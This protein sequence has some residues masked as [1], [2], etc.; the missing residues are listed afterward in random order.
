MKQSALIA[1]HEQMPPWNAGCVAT[2]QY[3]LLGCLLGCQP[4]CWNAV[5]ACGLLFEVPGTSP[6]HRVGALRSAATCLP[7]PRGCSPGAGT[8]WCSSKSFV[9]VAV[10]PLCNSNSN[11][12]R[13]A[14]TSKTSVAV[15]LRS[16][17]VRRP[18]RCSYQ[19][20][21]PIAIRKC[22]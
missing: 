3:C 4:G 22:V 20:K 11:T 21:Q 14:R 8:G 10:R 16:I 5:G 13:S 6:L 7:L 12:P 18:A 2:R 17:C 15:V 1:S 9:E 19:A